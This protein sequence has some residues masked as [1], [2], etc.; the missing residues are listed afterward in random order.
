MYR[1]TFEMYCCEH[2][3]NVYC[4]EEV[5]FEGGRK[6]PIM[7]AWKEKGNKQRL[8]P[9]LIGDMNWKKMIEDL[10]EQDYVTIEAQGM[11]PYATV[12]ELQT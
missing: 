1:E 11:F 3:W 8:W 9:L 5:N 2:G 4:S 10:K 6:V 7:N 12:N